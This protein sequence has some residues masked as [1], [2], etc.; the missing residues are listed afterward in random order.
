[1]HTR[2]ENYSLLLA[3]SCCNKTTLLAVNQKCVCVVRMFV[4]LC[5]TP[6]TR[7]TSPDQ[8]LI[9]FRFSVIHNDATV[10][11]IRSKFS[12]KV[13]T[14]PVNGLSFTIRDKDGVSGMER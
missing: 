3:C 13:T 1:M 6:D 4:T 9:N 2:L 11:H 5:L 10:R 14:L 8:F 12:N 7:I